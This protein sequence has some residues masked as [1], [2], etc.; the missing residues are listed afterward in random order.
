[1]FLDDCAVVAHAVKVY[2]DKTPKEEITEEV[3]GKLIYQ[4]INKINEARRTRQHMAELAGSVG[5]WD[6]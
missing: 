1:M 5:Y 6:R 2:I 4:E 3:L